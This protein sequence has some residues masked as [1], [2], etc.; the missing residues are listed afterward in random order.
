MLTHPLVCIFLRG[1]ADGLSL[2]PPIGDRHYRRLRPTL[3]VAAPDDASATRQER[4]LDLD[5]FFGL[6]P[7]LAPLMP[8]FRA[9]RMGIVHAVGSDD[10]TRS[11]FEAQDRMEH[12]DSSASLNGSGWLARLL[13]A[14]RAGSSPLRAVALGRR[15]PESLL[16][17]PTIAVFEEASEHRLA[18]G[19]DEG[20][21]PALS[22]LYAGDGA[23][24]AAGRDALSASRRL[25][26]TAGAPSTADYP[27]HVFG[28]RLAELA[29]LLR[30]EAGVEIATV[31]FDGWDTHFVQQSTLTDNASVLAGGLAAFV[32]DLGGLARRTT[33]LVMTEF[34]RRAQEN[35]S[36]GTD[37]G[38]GS[39]LFAIGHGVRGGRVIGPWP[40]LGPEDLEG[41]GDL[42]VTTS[43]RRVLA[44]LVERVVGVPADAV[45]SGLSGA[46]AGLFDAG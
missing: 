36:L 40:G 7:S 2:V 37:H 20:Y 26:A 13:R 46:D 24:E 12:G 9:R 19:R 35:G 14:S 45:F 22:G 30:V 32:D 39:V 34:G 15:A 17:A 28:R 41:P 6:H 38:R 3:A 8:L 4:A 23:V 27:D 10:E 21:L 11:H 1:G 25:E 33:I 42:R 31:D 16:G 43:Y 18:L 29:R 5:G 44:G